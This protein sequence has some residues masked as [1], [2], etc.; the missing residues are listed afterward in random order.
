MEEDFHRN[1]GV[2]PRRGV[3]PPSRP[4][5]PPYSPMG[6]A[7]DIVIEALSIPAP[8]TAR[9]AVVRGLIAICKARH[10]RYLSVNAITA[11]KCSDNPRLQSNR[12]PRKYIQYILARS[13]ELP[14]IRPISCGQRGRVGGMENE[15]RWS[16]DSHVVEMNS[17]TRQL[18]HLVVHSDIDSLVEA[19]RRA[20]CAFSK[21]LVKTFLPF[22]F[23]AT[24]SGNTSTDDR[25]LAVIPLF[26]LD[27]WR[28]IGRRLATAR[29]FVN[30]LCPPGPRGII[31][32]GHGRVSS[33]TKG[34]GRGTRSR[35]TELS[36]FH[37][38]LSMSTSVLESA[39]DVPDV[40]DDTPSKLSFR[41]GQHERRRCNCRDKNVIEVYFKRDND[42]Y[43]EN[44]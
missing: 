38:V 43:F 25:C 8:D 17:D 3:P 21:A 27:S 28:E 37:C 32:R 1:V 41:I 31:S 7:R 36:A 40:A 30:R 16:D 24:S 10:A 26:R 15:R 5:S 33:R 19:P 20:N 22:V 23:W 39:R 44:I 9:L 4:L 11:A 14:A 18:N 35:K 12:A 42:S 13:A 6:F 2:A 29:L 34:R